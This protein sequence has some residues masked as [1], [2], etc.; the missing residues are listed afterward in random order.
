L[1][2]IS[3]IGWYVS[4]FVPLIHRPLRGPILIGFA[5]AISALALLPAAAGAG[6]TNHHL[7]FRLSSPEHQD[8][9]GE[10]AILIRAR[11][12]GEPCRVVASAKSKKP[13]LHTGKAR[14]QLAAGTSETLSL[15]LPKLQRGKLKAALEAGR[16]PVFTVEATARDNAGTHIP[17]TIEVRAEKP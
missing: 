4:S 10:G 17:L 1:T 3:G 16:S 12:L 11:C 15:P 5:A 7:E 9:V 6:S 14:A 2:F 13:L 8:M